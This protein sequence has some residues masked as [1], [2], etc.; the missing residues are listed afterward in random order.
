MKMDSLGWFF[1]GFAA[2][3]AVI[4]LCMV[5]VMW[6]IALG[7]SPKSGALFAAISVTVAMALL[8]GFG[9]V[10]LIKSRSE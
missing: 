10:A 3:M 7:F 2:A 8:C 1:I 4:M 6:G 9:A 5:G